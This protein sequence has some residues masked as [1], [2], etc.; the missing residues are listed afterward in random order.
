LLYRLTPSERQVAVVATV[1]GGCQLNQELDRIAAQRP[2]LRRRDDVMREPEE[3]V[4]RTAA[5]EPRPLVLRDRLSH[6]APRRLKPLRPAA[7][8]SSGLRVAAGPPASLHRGSPPSVRSPR[9]WDR[10]SAFPAAQTT[11][12]RYP[13]AQRPAGRWSAPTGRAGSGR[14]QSLATSPAT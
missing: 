2:P 5:T 8:G 6:V 4:A 7:S 13:A 9:P 10:R 14:G 1:V 12:C 3:T 11:L